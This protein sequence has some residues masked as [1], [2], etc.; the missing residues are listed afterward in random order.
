MVTQ[1]ITDIGGH[2]VGTVETENGHSPEDL[3]A[4]GR[5]MLCPI[6]AADP[7]NWPAPGFDV[8]KFVARLG[9]ILPTLSNFNLRFELAPIEAYA[10]AQNWTGLNWYFTQLVNGGVA[11]QDDFDKLKGVLLEQGIQL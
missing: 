11:T 6:C 8:D 1:D 7:A 9:D 3:A 10:N 2:I 4:L 5:K